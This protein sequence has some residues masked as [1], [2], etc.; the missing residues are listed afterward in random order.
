MTA[1]SE[2]TVRIVSLTLTGNSAHII[3]G[4]LASVMDWVDACIVIDTGASDETLA[5]ARA[6]AGAKFIGSAFPW[7]DD[8]AAARNFALALALEQGA[9]WAVMLDTDERLQLHGLEIREA[10]SEAA[11]ELLAVRHESAVYS[12][13]RFFRLPAA[14]HYVGPTHE[15]YVSPLQNRVVLPQMRFTEIAKTTEEYQQKFERDARIL[16]QYSAEHP[17][18]PRWLYY[19]G[20]ALQNLRCC[21]EA[22]AAYQ[23][24]A[25][26]KG[27][28]A[29]AAWACYRAAECRIA[30]GDL[31]GAVESCGLGLARHAGVAELAWLAAYASWQ[32]GRVLQAVAWARLSTAMGCFR[33]AGREVAR[34]GFRN[35]FA[36]YEGPYDVL[37]FG[38]RAA[39]DDRAADEAERLFQEAAVMRQREEG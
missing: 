2:H 9:N 29:E 14:G 32:A 13:D 25:A 15:C 33:G 21:E 28:D 38:L 6:T 3:A 30:L 1:G 27:W 19:L 26:L 20:D 23:A 4:A 36:L 37:R 35:P 12:K 11:S 8:F 17:N 16:R 22:V 31:D 18:D 10:L 24:C 39:G 34:I 5:I 7:V